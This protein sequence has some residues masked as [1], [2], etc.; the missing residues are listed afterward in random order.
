[1]E[2]LEGRARAVSPA[3]YDL[4]FA[5]VLV[6]LGIV[7]VYGQ[8]VSAGLREPSP[9]GVLAAVGGAAPVA[10]RRRYPIGALVTSLA[11]TLV[12]YGAG[13]PEG[14]LPYNALI[15]TYSAASWS[16]PRRAAV[17]L[18]AALLTIIS[19]GLLDRPEF[20]TIT[21]LVI[22]AGTW[23]GGSAA[24]WRRESLKAELRAATERAEIDR[25]RSARLVAEER[26]RIAQELHDVVAHSMSVIAV[27][28]GAGSHLLHDDPDQAQRSLDSISATSRATL[29]ELRRL[30]GV[31]RDDTG[32]R[33]HLPAPGVADL[34]QLVAEVRDLGLPVELHVEGEPSGANPAI[35]LS[36]Y[37][38]VQEALTNVIKHAGQPTAVLV[39]LDHRPEELY[40]RVTD[41]GRG[42]SSRPGSLPRTGHGLVGMQERVDAWGGTLATGLRPEGGFVVEASLPFEERR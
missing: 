12:Y 14:S 13:F 25:Q 21:L 35:E 5:V 24:R 38:V 40:I 36:A 34:P 39:T 42:V 6:G 26:L 3:T 2:R 30:L 20:E 10:V 15:L 27:Q 28:A 8:D 32:A 17:G 29:A 9:L 23:L 22:F 33:S 31:L 16:P 4:I 11:V 41:D 18:A 19:L 7:T 37:R 1:M